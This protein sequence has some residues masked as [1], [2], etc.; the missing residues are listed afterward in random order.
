MKQKIEFVL[1]LRRRDSRT[2]NLTGMMCQEMWLKHLAHFAE[3]L[4]YCLS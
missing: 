2:A 1:Y 3:L 4:V